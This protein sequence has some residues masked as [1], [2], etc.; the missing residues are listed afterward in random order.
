MKTHPKY[1]MGPLIFG[2]LILSLFLSL[3]I[4]RIRS[5]D[6]PRKAAKPRMSAAHIIKSYAPF[7]WYPYNKEVFHGVVLQNCRQPQAPV[8]II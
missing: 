1:I 3:L 2:G 8:Y 7:I 4:Y 6:R 5:V